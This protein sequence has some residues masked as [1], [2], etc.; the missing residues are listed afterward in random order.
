MARLF[1]CLLIL[2]LW[3]SSSEGRIRILK[4]LHPLI[5]EELSLAKSC[6]DSNRTASR[7]DIESLKAV[8]D[9]IWHSLRVF[10]F[11][12]TKGEDQKLR[13]SYVLMQ[14][15]LEKAQI[16]A[17]RSGL[18]GSVDAFIITPR[19]PTP[20]TFNRGIVLADIHIDDPLDFAKYRSGILRSFL[21][22]GCCLHA[23]Y[24]REIS[25]E[26]YCNDCSD[27]IYRKYCHRYKNLKDM[28]LLSVDVAGFPSQ[29]SGALYYIDGHPI[30]VESKQV[31]MAGETGLQVWAIRFGKAAERRIMELNQF[32]K[33]NGCEDLV[34]PKALR[35]VEF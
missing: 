27:K 17:Y 23:V 7:E 12:E 2:C 18:A 28:P 15:I 24:C 14:G 10:G 34:F 33:E 3:G 1:Y 31:A 25:G 22:E 8:L 21:Y 13:P 35:Q 32:L 5:E 30:A 6:L 9:D 19:R 29:M 11:S 26:N 4:E 16:R 20:L